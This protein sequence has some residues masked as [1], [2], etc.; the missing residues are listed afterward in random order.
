MSTESPISPVVDLIPD[1]LPEFNVDWSKR[2]G[3]SR[4][5]V[6]AEETWNSDDS[7]L[8]VTALRGTGQNFCIY[9]INTDSD[10]TNF[11]KLLARFV[12]R[13]LRFSRPSNPQQR[14][15]PR[16]GMRQIDSTFRCASEKAQENV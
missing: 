12:T 13:M 15:L 7:E 14:M 5:T 9:D 6:K 16:I 10:W 2:L 8:M 11:L 4:Q 3:S 1:S